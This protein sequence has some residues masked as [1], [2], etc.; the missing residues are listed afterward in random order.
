[1]IVDASAILA[2]LLGEPK[3]DAILQ[4]TTRASLVSAASLPWEVGNALSA[5]VKRGRLAEKDARNAL[6]LFFKVPV[7]LVEVD[8]RVCLDIAMA[9]KMYAYDAY[10]IGAARQFSLPLVTLDAAL[11][12]I[13]RSLGVTIVEIP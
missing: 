13:A 3:R 9:Q 10:L 6:S 8:M 4:V 7:R 1:M 12:R 2:T 5:M 11:A